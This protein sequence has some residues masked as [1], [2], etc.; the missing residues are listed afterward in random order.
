MMSTGLAFHRTTVERGNWLQVV[1]VKIDMV[2]DLWKQGN[3][4]FEII[5]DYSKTYY[6]LFHQR[7]TF[8]FIS[9]VINIVS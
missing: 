6:F 8:L 4:K 7:C 1:W 9:L 3:N 2:R 5:E